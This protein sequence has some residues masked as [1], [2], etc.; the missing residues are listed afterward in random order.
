MRAHCE[1]GDIPRAL[2]IVRSLRTRGEPLPPSAYKDLA[3]LA[4]RTRST[5]PLLALKPSDFLTSA[6][7]EITPLVW[8][9][10]NEVNL[11]ASNLGTVE[12]AIVAALAGFLLVFTVA[13]AL[14]LTHTPE[15]DPF[16]GW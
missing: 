9:V 12:R 11:A 5:G 7:A 10:G 1:R 6:S 15:V 3:K 16:E 4:L 8:A 2:G 14:G 13:S